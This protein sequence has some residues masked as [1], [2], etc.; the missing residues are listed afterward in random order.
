MT[1]YTVHVH[2]DGTGGLWA[3]VAEL[4]GCFAAGDSW[5]EL[6]ESLGEGIALYLADGPAVSS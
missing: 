4:P 2:D 6:G 5:A 3:A 1:D